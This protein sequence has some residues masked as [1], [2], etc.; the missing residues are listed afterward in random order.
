M[1]FPSPSGH[2]IT[3]ASLDQDSPQRCPV[4]RIEMNAKSHQFWKK[5]SQGIS[6]KRLLWQNGSSDHW[7]AVRELQIPVPGIG[8]HGPTII[9]PKACTALKGWHRGS[10]CFRNFLRN[11]LAYLK[12]QFSQAGRAVRG[13]DARLIAHVSQNC[14]W[15]GL[16]WQTRIDGV[17]IGIKLIATLITTAKLLWTQGFQELASSAARKSCLNGLEWSGCS[18]STI[19]PRNMTITDGLCIFLHPARKSGA[20]IWIWSWFQTLPGA[21]YRSIQLVRLGTHL[22][23]LRAQGFL[24]LA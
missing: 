20:D 6:L 13:T 15:K 18:F 3:Q 9:L 24:E 4:T 16:P 19:F 5:K 7:G 12:G 11:Q 22:K 2:V 8:S 10:A 17:W 14:G 21:L 1:R 23:L